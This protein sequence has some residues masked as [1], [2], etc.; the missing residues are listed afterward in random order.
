MIEDT[1]KVRTER[2]FV[3]FI[4]GCGVAAAVLFTVVIVLLSV[5]ALRSIL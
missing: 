4:V 1:E 3:A 5:D 2:A